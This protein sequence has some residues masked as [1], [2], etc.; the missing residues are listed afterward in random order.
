MVEVL[1]A[2]F[3]LYFKE[4]QRTSK[5]YRIIPIENAK[6]ESEVPA[7]KTVKKYIIT[8]AVHASHALTCHYPFYVLAAPREDI[9][10]GCVAPLLTSNSTHDLQVKQG[11][12]DNCWEAPHSLWWLVLQPLSCTAIRL[13]RRPG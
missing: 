7:G 5:L 1:Q 2:P 8:V 12:G 10:V 11:R 9:Q 3:L 4:R 6:I 13:C